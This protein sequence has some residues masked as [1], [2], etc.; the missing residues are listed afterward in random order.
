MECSVNKITINI[1]KYPLGKS[2]HT[3]LESGL[4]VE[5]PEEMYEMTSKPARFQPGTASPKIK[6]LPSGSLHASTI[7]QPNPLHKQTEHSRNTSG[8]YD[9][10]I[11]F[12]HRHNN[13]I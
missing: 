4:C 1:S 5:K 2:S 9:Q 7:E 11:D 8:S 6:K 13:G 3:D 12:V 10:D